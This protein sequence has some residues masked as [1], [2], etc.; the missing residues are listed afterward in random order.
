[1]KKIKR[2][3][4]LLFKSGKAVFEDSNIWP[5][6]SPIGVLSYYNALN[7][8]C[9]GVMLRG[10]G[11]S[12]DLHKSQPYE[13]YNEISFFSFIGQH[14]DCFNRYLIRIKEMYE[15]CNIILQCLNLIDDGSF[16]AINNKIT[17]PSRFFMKFSIES[18]IHH[19]KLF[20]EGFTIPKNDIYVDVEAPKWDFG[21]HL[22]SNGTNLP[23]RC[24]IKAPGFSHLQLLKYLSIGHMIADVVTIIGTLDIVFG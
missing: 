19:F 14:G 2:I 3:F 4:N 6:L 24:K 11:I 13:I 5:I 16:I 15:S 20:T 22:F 12:C 7:W 1:M 23:Y 18:L 10:S 9:S 8:S 21:V 17:I